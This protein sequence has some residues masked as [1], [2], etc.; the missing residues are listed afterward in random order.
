MDIQKRSFWRPEITFS[1]I[2]SHISTIR[3]KRPFLFTIHL[4]T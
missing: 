4:F 2:R 1:A 3:E